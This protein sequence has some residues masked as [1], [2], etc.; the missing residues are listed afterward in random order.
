MGRRHRREPR[1]PLSMAQHMLASTQGLQGNL[2]P[3]L[4]L[5]P[6]A[7][8]E[9]RVQQVLLDAPRRRYIFNLGHGL[10]PEIPP[11][12]VEALVEMVHRL[13]QTTTQP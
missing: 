5:G 10:T 12:H 9:Q 13:G 3:L 6:L 1:Q 7:Q 8:L 11:A 4:L 2:E